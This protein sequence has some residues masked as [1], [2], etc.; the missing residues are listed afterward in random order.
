MS[1]KSESLSAEKI[2]ALI[3]ADKCLSPS[4]EWYENSNFCLIFNW[5]YLKKEKNKAFSPANIINLFIV[6]KLNSWWRNLDSN[7][8]LKDFFSGGFKLAEN[9][10]PDKSLCS[11]YSIGF[12]TWR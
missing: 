7:L 11:G 2:T 10:D 8:T 12:V 1:W 3:T 5:S 4:I 6:Y 9:A